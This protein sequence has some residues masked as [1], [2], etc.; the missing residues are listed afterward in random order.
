MTRMPKEF[1]LFWYIGAVL[2]GCLPMAIP[3]SIQAYHDIKELLLE[4]LRH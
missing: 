3:G 4:W 1:P 2:V